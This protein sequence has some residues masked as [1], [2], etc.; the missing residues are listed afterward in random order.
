MPPRKRT[1]PVSA[2]NETEP[3]P[4]GESGNPGPATVSYQ[5]KYTRCNKPTCRRC[6]EGPGHGPDWSALWW[7]GGRTRTRYVGKTLPEGVMVA[8]EPPIPVSE[9]GAVT[10][11]PSAAAAES[12]SAPGATLRA[13]TLGR[14][15]VMIDETPL[16]DTAWPRRKAILLFKLLLTM[17]NRRL[18]REQVLERLWPEED[19]GTASAG[20]RGA[21]HG[22]RRALELSVGDAALQTQGGVIALADK[23][24]LRLDADEFVASANLALTGNDIAS[25]RAALVS[26]TGDYLPDDLYE[27]WAET[28][29]R[30]LATLRIAV[31]L[32][33][34]RLCGEGGDLAEARAAL[35]AVLAGDPAHE[36]AATRQM[37]ILAAMGERSEALRVFERLEAAL[38][39]QLGVKPNR[40]ALAL[41]G[42]LRDRGKP[43][44]ARRPAEAATPRHSNLPAAL[45]TFVGRESDWESVRSALRPARLVTLLGAGGAGKTRLALRVA[46]SM[47]EEYP[48]GVW[49][50]ELAG[51]APTIQAV[52]DEDGPDP[53]A[54]ALAGALGLLEDPTCSLDTT[55]GAFLEPRRMLL[56][57]DNCEHVLDPAARL[58]SF[59]LTTCSE[60]S[61][62]AT[63]REA[64]G[65]PGE[66]VWTV[67]P[68]SLP[69]PG[70][71]YSAAELEGFDAI[72][73]FVERARGS[74]PG[75][76]LNEATA[77][78]VLEVCRRLDGIPLAIELAAARLAF[79]SLENLAARL[80]DRFRLLVGGSRIALPRQQTLRAAMDWSYG[81][82]GENERTLLLRLTVFAGGWTLDAAEGVC[83]DPD[84]PE[85]LILDTLGGL[86]AKS[87]VM[88]QTDADWGRYGMLET[89][90]QYGQLKL[91]ESPGRTAPH[92]R[93]LAWFAQHCEELIAGWNASDQASLLRRFDADLDNIRAALAWGLGPDGNGVAA[94]RLTSALSRYWTTRGL[95]GEGRRWTAQALDAAPHAPAPLRATA[96]NRCAIL[97]RT[98][99][100][101]PTAATLWEAALMLFRE[102][103]D[104]AGVARVVGN[105]GMLHY[106]NE[107]D[108]RALELLTES[109]ALVRELGNL[110][111]VARNAQNLGVVYT[112]QKRYAEAEATFAEAEAIHQA[113]DNQAGLGDTLLHI[114][115][116]AR[117]QEH[118]DRAAQLYAASLRIFLDMGDRP[119]VAPALEGLAHVLLRRYTKGT[120][121]QLLLEFGTRLFACA[122]ALRESTGVPI[123]TVSQLVYQPDLHQLHALMGSEAFEAAWTLGWDTPVLSLL[124]HFAPSLRE[125]RGPSQGVGED[126]AVSLTL[127]PMTGSDSTV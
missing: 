108:H 34:A 36:D 124:E 6:A 113:T 45:S 86:A 4:E 70:L 26:Y 97:A 92:T 80:E 50:C 103:G 20:L 19:E 22:I 87:L 23:A 126:N 46:E 1:P 94:L 79:L 47:V 105:L 82:L 27:D 15:A 95:V 60:I 11:E 5:Q 78:G 115:H 106:D 118:L 71:T 42:R 55:I 75:F 81:L 69:E 40:E 65:L 28:R 102:Q 24:V 62:L 100:D 119:R 76:V 53:V 8:E 37:T 39:E 104:G 56:V 90:R 89:I 33:L 101:N 13:I 9:V 7:E 54:R 10:N 67:P 49:L 52:R 64:L 31:L 44:A 61:V 73:L 110:Q 57:V 2:T 116:L 125:G 63:S 12:A 83:T 120:R 98:Q 127:V 51:L 114:A 35:G 25:C 121:E 29:R 107:D 85:Y 123:P 3:T 48:D 111:D 74:R 21:T 93:H 68:L 32:H 18:T 41:A 59:L 43:Q 72:G 88:V 99:G 84:L 14:F 38:D 91:A 109:L 117:D 122:A 30:E 96:L 17:P 112:R 66:V 77:P 16:P 58:V